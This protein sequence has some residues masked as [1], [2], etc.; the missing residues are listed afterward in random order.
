MNNLPLLLGVERKNPFHGL[1]G[2]RNEVLRVNRFLPPLS[3][4]LRGKE[5][6]IFSVSFFLQILFRDE[7]ER[8]G[9]HAVP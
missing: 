4:F 8:G 1:P 2:G 7:P 3:L 9:I 6:Q 5:L